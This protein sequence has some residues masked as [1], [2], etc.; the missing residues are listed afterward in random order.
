[1][2]HIPSTAHVLVLGTGLTAVDSALMLLRSGHEGPI[3]MVSRRGLLPAVRS[4]TAAAPLRYLDASALRRLL[5]IT[6][7]MTCARALA[8]LRC[9]FRAAGIDIRKAA[10]DFTHVEDPAQRL[11]RQVRQAGDGSNT[12]QPV[13]VQAALE[14]VEYIWQALP[15]TERDRF[16]S[17]WHHVFNSLVN[18]MPPQTAVRLLAA[19]DEGQL[20]VHRGIRAIVPTKVGFAAATAQGTVTADVVVNAV[21]Q[22]TG[23][24]NSAAAPLVDSLLTASSARVHPYGGIDVEPATSRVLDRAG[25]PS[26]RLF[27]LGQLTCGVHYYTSSMTMIAK[28]SA[29]IADELKRAVLS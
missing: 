22:E 18:P 14:S 17:R 20:G 2:Q 21:R 10:P 9:E 12:W 29:Q 3:N 8:L 27:A 28:R 5:V 24:T 16:M 1:L 25:V 13:L 4:F 26:A 15:A 11:R 19:I 23:V 7:I 6:P